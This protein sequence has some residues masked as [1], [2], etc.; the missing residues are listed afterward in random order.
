MGARR[1]AGYHV[2]PFA[3]EWSGMARPIRMLALRISR[4]PYS[5]RWQ[6]LICTPISDAASCWVSSHSLQ[7][8]HIPVGRENWNFFALFSTTEKNQ[9]FQTPGQKISLSLTT[10]TGKGQNGRGWSRATKKQQIFFRLTAFAGRAGWRLIFNFES[11]SLDF[12]NELEMLF[13]IRFSFDG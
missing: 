12:L 5:S 1:R 8:R 9:K 13:P 2:P 6:A 4:S 7:H 3:I 11:S 10:I